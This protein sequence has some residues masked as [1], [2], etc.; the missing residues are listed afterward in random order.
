MDKE[1]QSFAATPTSLH[2][3]TRAEKVRKNK[4]H[5]RSDGSYYYKKVIVFTGNVV[6]HLSIKVELI[7]KL[8]EYL[9]LNVMDYKQ[10]LW[11]ITNCVQIEKGTVLAE[12]TTFKYAEVKEN[13]VVE[14]DDFTKWL[15]IPP[16]SK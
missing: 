10:R 2:V 16:M 15:I 6:T 11:K 4:R 1:L 7:G 5:Y 8:K 14:L 3:V 13:S 12:L 9:G